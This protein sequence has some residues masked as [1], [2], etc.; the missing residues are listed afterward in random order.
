MNNKWVLQTIKCRRQKVP[1]EIGTQVHV[2][3][4]VLPVW[5]LSQCG[6]TLWSAGQADASGEQGPPRDQREARIG[7]SLGMHIGRLRGLRSCHQRLISYS[8]ECARRIIGQES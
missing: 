8:G 1:R 7:G 2:L 5:G 3:D 4:K 6:Q